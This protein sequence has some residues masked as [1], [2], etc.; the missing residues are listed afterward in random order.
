M[1]S[2]PPEVLFQIFAHAC[3][4]DGTTARSLAQVSTYIHDVSLPFQWQSLAVCGLDQAQALLVTLDANPEPR[5]KP[6][7]HLFLSDRTGAFAVVDWYR[8]RTPND[9]ADAARLRSFDYQRQP[10]RDAQRQLLS[11][12]APTLQTLTVLFHDPY[13]SFRCIQ[14]VLKLEYPILEEITIRGSAWE[15]TLADCLS[16]EVN[17]MEDTMPNLRK[18]HL[19]GTVAFPRVVRHITTRSPML[20]HLRLSGM[21][22]DI[23]F[24]RKLHAEL[25]E[26][27]MAPSRLAPVRESPSGWRRPV[28]ENIFADDVHWQRILPD[29][30]QLFIAQPMRLPPATDCR[31]CSGYAATEW[32]THV[33]REIGKSHRADSDSDATSE[34]EDSPRASFTY[35]PAPRELYLYEEA[36]NDWIDSLSGGPGCWNGAWNFELDPWSEESEQEDSIGNIGSL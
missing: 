6:I 23:D 24:A 10:W 12:A 27:R 26:R 3:K 16:S 34:N 19:V 17:V 21:A 36:K 32:V 15:P 33:I 31:C 9:E 29:R 5:R 7:R 35:L 22:R 25:Y 11:Y 8:H 14:D 30:L 1:E 18:V 2:C 13:Q 20:S 28:G 4:D